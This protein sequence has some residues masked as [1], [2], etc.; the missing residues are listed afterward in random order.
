M[1][2]L[3]FATWILL[4]VCHP[5]LAGTFA[6]LEPGVSTRADVERVLGPPLEEA[7]TGGFQFDPARFDAKSVEVFYRPGSEVVAIIAVEP[8]ASYSRSDYREWF[9]LGEPVGGW[10]CP[11]G[12]WLEVCFTSRVPMPPIRWIASVTSIPPWHGS[13]LPLSQPPRNP[14]PG[15]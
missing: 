10:R 2:H 5:C 6:G 13:G 7:S 3:C 14:T 15:S 8:T 1:R 11:E 9:G 4:W 12:H